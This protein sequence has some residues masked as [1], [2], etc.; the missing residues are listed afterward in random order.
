MP[1]PV[2]YASV[3]IPPAIPDFFSASLTGRS[4]DKP[5]VDA[6]F[7]GLLA[8]ARFPQIA[9]HLHPHPGIGRAAKHLFDQDRHIGPKCRMTIEQ[10]RQRPCG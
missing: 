8:L 7:V 5:L 2:N 9:L 4:F 1:A 10:I 6:D 3:A